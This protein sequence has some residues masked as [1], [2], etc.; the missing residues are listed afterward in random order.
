MLTVT[1]VIISGF[2]Q[3]YKNVSYDSVAQTYSPYLVP[4]KIAF[5]QNNDY[6]YRCNMSARD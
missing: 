1:W 5:K 2:K 4:W 3:S 6:R